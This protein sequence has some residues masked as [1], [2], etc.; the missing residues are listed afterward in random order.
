MT[1][2]ENGAAVELDGMAIVVAVIGGVG[3]MPVG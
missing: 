3:G 1:C 2:G